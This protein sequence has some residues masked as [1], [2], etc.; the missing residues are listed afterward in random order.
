MN[1]STKQKQ[2]HRLRVQ[3]LPRGKEEGERWTR[4]LGLVA[5]NYFTENRETRSYCT[6]KHIQ[7]PGINYI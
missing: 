4:S 1:T 2:I 3:K 7:F 5:A 6:R